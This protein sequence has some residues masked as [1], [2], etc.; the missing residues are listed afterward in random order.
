VIDDP[1]RA[2]QLA[3]SISDDIRLYNAEKIAARADV[4]AEIEE[5]RALYRS[6]VAPPLHA[7]FDDLAREQFGYSPRLDIPPPQDSPRQA[8]LV[9]PL[10][11]AV[12]LFSLGVALY[13][14]LLHR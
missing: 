3:Q 12:A 10:A 11:L 2:R 1:A 14:F 5:G 7:I 6:R 8:S 9:T 4:S 13:F